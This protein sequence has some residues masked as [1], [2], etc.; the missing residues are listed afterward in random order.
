MEVQFK[1]IDGIY[2]MPYDTFVKIPLYKLLIDSSDYTFEPN[3]LTDIINLEYISKYG[4]KITHLEVITHMLDDI[5]SIFTYPK[6]YMHYVNEKFQTYWKLRD[7][8]KCI[9]ICNYWDLPY[10]VELFGIIYLIYKGNYSCVKN[11]NTNTSNFLTDGEDG[12]M[13]IKH[14]AEIYDVLNKMQQIIKINNI[15]N[16]VSGWNR[17]AQLTELEM[18]YKSMMTTQYLPLIDLNEEHLFW[19]F[20]FLTINPIFITKINSSVTTCTYASFLNDPNISYKMWLNAIKHNHYYFEYMP[21]S[22][23]DTIILD[24]C[25]KSGDQ[26]CFLRMINDFPDLKTIK[27]NIKD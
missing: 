27:N 24:E 8:Y 14:P 10:L 22:M 21:K 23:I 7:I 6:F 12:R 4:V 17:E 9:L 26:T 1:C 3:D 20:I 25:I 19:T 5:T 2:K 13:R 15:N 18:I 11:K 16:C